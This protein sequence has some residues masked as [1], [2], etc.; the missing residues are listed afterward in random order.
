MT[1][2]QTCA[3]PISGTDPTV[4]ESGTE[5]TEYHVSPDHWDTAETAG[6]VTSSTAQEGERPVSSS[7]SCGDRSESAEPVV[8]GPVSS[9]PEEQW[10]PYELVDD[11][12]QEAAPIS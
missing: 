9:E 6:G 2:V 5:R 1:G 11:L 12:A 3:L 7:E 10:P 4:P 8:I